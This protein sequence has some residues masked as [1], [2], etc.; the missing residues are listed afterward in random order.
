MRMKE[1]GLRVD[2]VPVDMRP[3]AGGESK[4][5]GKKAVGLVVTVIAT[6]VFFNLRRRR[7]S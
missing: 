4:L 7:G 2:E 5:Q 6:L 3:R 1:A